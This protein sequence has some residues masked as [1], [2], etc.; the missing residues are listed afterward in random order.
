[1]AEPSIARQ[2]MSVREE[3]M[4]VSVVIPAHNEAENIKSLVH[5]VCNSLSGLFRFE[6]IV[7]DDCSTDAMS[8][9]LQEMKPFVAELRVVRH[10][11]QCGQSAALITGI[12]AAIAPVIATLDGDGQ[13]DPSDLPA[14][15]DAILQPNLADRVQL[16]AGQRTRRKDSA[17]RRVSSWIAN[18]VRGRI[19]GDQTADSGC[20]IKVFYRDTFLKLPRFTHMHRFLPA[21][22]V[23]SGGRVISV[24]VKHRP[25]IHGRSH[26]DTLRRLISGIIDL[27]GVVWLMHRTHIPVIELMDQAHDERANLDNLRFTGSAGIQREVRRSVA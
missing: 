21:L 12:D 10:A 24:P 11:N 20:G 16:V 27:A 9:V 15:L 5:E 17:W 6:I 1:M 23:R 13:N 2:R 4:Q 26:Y 3:L 25:R 22:V 19:L 18:S 14:M 7:V 8:A